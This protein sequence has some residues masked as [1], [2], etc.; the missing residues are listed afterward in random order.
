MVVCCVALVVT[1]LELLLLISV[2][3]TIVVV[4]CV[5]VLVTGLELP[6]LISVFLTIVVVCCVALVVTGLELLL[7]MSVLFDVFFK[8]QLSPL[9]RTAPVFN[10]LFDLLFEIIVCVAAVVL[11]IV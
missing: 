7:L 2:L 8:S 4:C 5:A 10:F 6:L 9:V 3:L 11:T 1:G